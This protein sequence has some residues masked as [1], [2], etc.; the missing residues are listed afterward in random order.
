MI[1]AI[2]DGRDAI[3]RQA[4]ESDVEGQQGVGS[5]RGSRKRVPTVPYTPTQ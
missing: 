2:R 3:A 4:L 1:N 5:A